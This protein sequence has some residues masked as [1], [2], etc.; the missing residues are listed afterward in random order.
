MPWL[1]IVLVGVAL[2]G[3]LSVLDKTVIHRYARMPYLQPLV[4]GITMMLIG[5]PLL[6][7]T[8]I[9][10]SATSEALL[11]ALASGVCYGLGTHILVYTLY[12]Q[13]VSRVIPVYQTYPIFTALIAFTFLGE[14]LD[15]FEWV[16][17]LAV[18]GG[19][20][21][22]SFRRDESGC[23]FLLD[24]AFI[25]LIIGSVIEGSSFVFGKSAVSDL[26]VLFTHA[27]R[28]IAIGSVLLALNL[29]RRSLEQ[30]L[31][32]VRTRSPA[33]KFVALNQL[34]ISNASQFLFLWALS[35]GP[36]TLVTALS[37]LRTFFV[38]VYAI[39]LSMVWRG[40]LGEV[41]T[42]ATVTV[43]LFSTMLIVSG[44]AVI[45]IGSG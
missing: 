31:W 16:A 1:A 36:T 37:S 20:V 44:V 39:A 30:V 29:R 5:L 42:P 3:L 23:G 10:S 19:A 32:F 22:L 21:L 15:A 27:V 7:W 11:A 6:A 8:G 17:M 2:A 38:V 4:I 33:L 25:V 43:K 9:P 13:E 28:L 18:V 34:V 40:A 24:R 14:R 35:L 12:R 45:A 41:S 26:P